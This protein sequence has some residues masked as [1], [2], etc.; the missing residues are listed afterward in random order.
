LESS[1]YPVLD[2]H[3]GKEA[4]NV[5]RIVLSGQG[6]IQQWIST[7]LSRARARSVAIR[8]FCRATEGALVW[9]PEKLT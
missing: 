1:G 2:I 7:L 4:Q 9:M 5:A 3:A 6:L 8:L